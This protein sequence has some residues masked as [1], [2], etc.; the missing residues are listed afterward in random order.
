MKIE[1]QNIQFAWK[2]FSDPGLNAPHAIGGKTP[3][4]NS[5]LHGIIGKWW[6]IVSV[7]TP[8]KGASRRLS[9]HV[10]TAAVQRGEPA[11]A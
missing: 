7:K 2:V 9:P 11:V 5:E 8:F 4:R 6:K 1:T 10:H 3:R